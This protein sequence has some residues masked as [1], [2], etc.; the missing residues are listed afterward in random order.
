MSLPALRN[1]L[2]TLPG[3]ARRLE[4]RH[5]RRSRFRWLVLIELPLKLALLLVVAACMIVLWVLAAV[6]GDGGPDF[7]TGSDAGGESRL[8]SIR[9]FEY[10]HELVLVVEGANGEV[11]SET[12]HRPADAAA[13][14]AALAAVL[15]AADREGLV[16]RETEAGAPRPLEVWYGGQPLLAHPE[17]RDAARAERLLQDAARVRVIEEE[18]TLRIVQQGHAMGRFKAAIALLLELIVSPLLI[19]T[20]SFRRTLRETWLDLQGAP[21]EEYL[22]AL[23]DDRRLTVERRRHERRDVLLALDARDLLGVAYSPTLGYDAKVTRQP[24][25][26][27]LLTRDEV[28]RL[29]FDLPTQAAGHALRDLLLARAAER[30]AGVPAV[31]LRPTKCPYCGRLY[32]FAAGAACPGCGAPAGA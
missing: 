14:H 28:H 1:A 5:V 22:V 20:A 19:W 29:A 3:A 15:A 26:L 17:V 30:W 18:G 6:L 32:P 11:L 21:P 7:D 2:E 13:G 24:P 27:R 4:L 12:V 23:H 25:A 9:F 31:T 16:V 10:W 8:L